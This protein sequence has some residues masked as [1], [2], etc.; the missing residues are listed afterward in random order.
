MRLLLSEIEKR[1]HITLDKTIKDGGVNGVMNFGLKNDYPQTIERI[2]NSSIS[3]KSVIGMKAKFLIGNGF[4]EGIDNFIIGKDYKGKD[5]TLAMLTSQLA[6]ELATFNGCYLHRNIDLNFKTVNAKY[7][8]FKWCRFAKPDDNGYI[9]KICVYE[10]WEKDNEAINRFDKNRIRNYHIFNSDQSAITAQIGGDI[11]KYTG[12]VNYLF[13]DNQYLYPLSPIDCVYYDCDSESQIS[14]YKNN[15]LR[16][17][18]LDK[19]L[20]RVAPAGTEQEQQDFINNLKKQLGADGDTVTV[21]EDEI[22]PNTGQIKENGAFKIETISSNI[23][24]KLF[25]NWETGI[26]N[27]IRKSNDALPAILID[28][29]ESNLG[30]TSG[31]AVKQAVAFYN[32]MTRDKRKALSYFLKETLGTMSGLEG[33]TFDIKELTLIDNLQINAQG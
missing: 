32:A 31:E 18:F 16:N 19:I 9:A 3:A 28:Y 30:T 20:I 29:V 10:N 33:M 8:P 27:N 4:V 5:Y 25:A 6:D 23:N 21:L 17:G 11:N 2:K 24:D 7:I 13:L 1:V 12:Q 15:Q 22:D 26:Y 14:I